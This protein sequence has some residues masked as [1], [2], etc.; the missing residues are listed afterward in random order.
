MHSAF[1]HG[2]I[3][4]TQNRTL[5]VNV[6]LEIVPDNAFPSLEHEQALMRE[7]FFDLPLRMYEEHKSEFEAATKRIHYHIQ[8]ETDAKQH[9]DAYV[10][11]S[12]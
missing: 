2:D 4:L 1:Y 12:F 9:D 6:P 3:L 8:R 10:F 5:H 11:L 7:T